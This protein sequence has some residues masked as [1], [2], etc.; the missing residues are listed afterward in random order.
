MPPLPQCLPLEPITLGNQKYPRPGELR[1][2]LGVPS[3]SEEHSFGV[4]HSKIPAPVGTDE[5]KHLKKSV[6]DGSR[7]ARYILFAVFLCLLHIHYHD[8]IFSLFRNYSYI[9][10]DTKIFS[11]V[12]MINLVGSRSGHLA[13]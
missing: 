7:K 5:L 13:L 9:V 8:T 12:M 3:T 6:Q 1:R 2:V 4:S 10:H 11:V